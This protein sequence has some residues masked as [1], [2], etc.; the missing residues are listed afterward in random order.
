MTKLNIAVVGLGVIGHQHIG[1][2]RASTRANLCAVVDTTQASK[3]YAKAQG[4]LHFEDLESLFANQKPDGV[5]L[6]TPNH[7]HVSGALIC[8]KNGVAA[9]IEKPVA[10]SVE[11]GERLVAVLKT[12]DVPMLVGHHRRHSAILQTA[13]KYIEAGHLG[14]LVTVIGS[15]QFYK[16]D[17]YFEAVWRTKKG[18]GPVLINLIHE[19]DN[20][21]FLCG[22]IVQVQAMA[23]N[24]VRGFEV[25]DTVVI[26]LK[27]KSGLLGTFTLSDTAVLPMSWEQTSGEDK[28]YANTDN[29]SLT[30]C[31]YIA[32]T[33]GGMAI[34]SLRTWSYESEKSWWNPF[35]KRQL[36]IENIDPLIAQ[37]DH[38]CEVIANKVEPI[39]SVADAL[40]SLKIVEAVQRTL[41]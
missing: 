11:A 31:Y 21:R 25:E 28:K 2:I 33:T 14:Q 3:D 40:E 22:D 41:V 39:V 4:L 35:T 9:L 1:R 27:F 34:P 30:D 19:M 29:H 10:D 26:M 16:P 7:L 17:T 24:A 13:K 8:A 6:A 37:L 5:V 20:L 18:A 12:Y 38:F 23:S 15:A 36:K 32:G